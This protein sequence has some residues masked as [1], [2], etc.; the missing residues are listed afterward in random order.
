MYLF[1]IVNFLGLLFGY[2]LWEINP[3]IKPIFTID[4]ITME[5]GA[6][7]PLTPN[8]NNVNVDITVKTDNRLY[9]CFLKT[10][11]G[12]SEGNYSYSKETSEFNIAAGGS[13]VKTITLPTRDYLTSNGMYIK[14]SLFYSE[15]FDAPK[16]NIDRTF[17]IHPIDAVS[18]IKPENYINAPCINKN[19][20]YL[21]NKF[22][23]TKENEQFQFPDYIDYFNID[24]YHRL[25]LDSV[26]FSYTC[27]R[28]FT[29]SAAYLR[30][31]DHTNAFPYI[32]KDGDD[33][34]MVP[35]K[36]IT[37]GNKMGFAFKNKFYVNPDTAQI[38]LEAKAGFVLTKYFYLPKNGRED[39]LDKKMD[40][41]LFGAGY[42][43]SNITWNLT[44]LASNNLLGD[45]SDS[46]Y[47]IVGEQKNG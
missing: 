38:S 41:L 46:D 19:V 6:F 40:V 4:T 8:C 9:G 44:F 17:V 37:V 1:K 33:A 28:S 12:L 27:K 22:T 23:L 16:K 14:L 45:C 24:T 3:G 10:Y 29:Y 47:C 32:S 13:V 25:N 43:S 18:N 30:I 11:A 36:V 7:G 21:L 2:F 26:T 15:T 31:Y 42:G 35:L 20:S 5:S 39:L 34:F